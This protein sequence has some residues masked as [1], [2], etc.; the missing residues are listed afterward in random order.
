MTGLHR[1]YVIEVKLGIHKTDVVIL[2]PE[3]VAS[4]DV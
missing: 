1:P 4:F 2:K 3:V